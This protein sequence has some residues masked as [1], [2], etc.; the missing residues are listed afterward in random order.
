MPILFNF[1]SVDNQE[2]GVKTAMMEVVV[3]Q[4][5][6]QSIFYKRKKR[7]SLSFHDRRKFMNQ[8]VFTPLSTDFRRR[9]AYLHCIKDGT[10]ID[11]ACGSGE[12]YIHRSTL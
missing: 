7:L 12:M 10:N 9:A 6:L 2:G 3:R 1:S 4:M 8:A 5:A 11:P